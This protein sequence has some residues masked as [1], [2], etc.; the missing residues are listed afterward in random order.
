MRTA[1]L[2]QIVAIIA[3]GF[4]A[5]STVGCCKIVPR[6]EPIPTTPP[7]DLGMVQ[8]PAGTPTTQAAMHAWVGKLAK[9]ANYKVTYALS[10]AEQQAVDKAATDYANSVK[11]VSKGN[12]SFNWT[13]PK[14]CS[15]GM[16]CVYEA[17]AAKNYSDVQPLI[18]RFKQQINASK[19][20]SL[21]ATTLVVNFVQNIQYEVPKDKPFGVLPPALVVSQKRGDCDSKSLLGHMILG[22][23]GLDT[24]LVSSNAHKHAMLAI[25]IPSSGTKINY[26]GRQYSF[27]EMTAKGSPVGYINPKLL[28]PNDW[29]P[30][31]VNFP[32]KK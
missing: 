24:I 20:N 26:E 21:D 16:R 11:Y 19:L 25:N 9:P 4:T 5:L 29:V 27:T 23:M 3:A 1:C 13:P 12:G 31:P 30:V 6:G 7:I 10:S 28:S 14:G 18:D 8:V 22:S 17:L 15:P 32:G 2:Q